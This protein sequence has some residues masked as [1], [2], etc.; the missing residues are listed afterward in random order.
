MKTRA[1]QKKP[2]QNKFYRSVASVTKVALL[3]LSVFL[4]RDRVSGMKT[5]IAEETTSDKIQNEAGDAKTKARKAG[6]A[7]KRKARKATG[8][9]SLM[10][11]AEDKA[12]DI[13]DDISNDADK[14]KRKVD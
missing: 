13:G 12:K 4:I 1:R 6:R 7:V 8:N 14:L 3:A 9:D 10:K 11:D 2:L 5:A